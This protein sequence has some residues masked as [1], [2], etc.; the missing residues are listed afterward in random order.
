[1]VGELMG[2]DSKFRPP[3][4]SQII[5]EAFHLLRNAALKLLPAYY[6]GSLPFVIGLLYFWADMSRA[7]DAR[8]YLGWSSLAVAALYVWMKCW[9]AV[10]SM[11]LREHIVGQSISAPASFRVTHLIVLQL[12]VHA[13]AFLVLPIAAIVVLPL[14]WCFA[15]YQNVT[16]APP[17]RYNSLRVICRHAWGQAVI[18]PRQNHLIIALMTLFSH[19]VALN[20]ALSIFALPYLIKKFFGTDT[21]FTLSGVNALNSTFWVIVLALTYLCLDPIFKAVYTLRCFYS[22][23]LKTGTD[24]KTELNQCVALQ[25]SEPS[26]LS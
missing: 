26:S 7:A 9:Q 14:G 1:M 19:F 22:E 20:L 3:G 6:I 16:S 8:Q 11:R 17:D 2:A 5:D 13:S 15:F 12:A 4:A 21:I 23:S 24:I 10:F 18:W 25:R